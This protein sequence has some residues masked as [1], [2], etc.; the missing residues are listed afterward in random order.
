MSQP[1]SPG[2]PGRHGLRRIGSLLGLCLAA[3]CGAG[4]AQQTARIPACDP[5]NGGITLPAGFCAAVFADEIGVARH[6]VVGPDGIVYV[7]LE[8][9]RR[10]SA[11]TSRRREEGGIVI[12]RDTTGDGRADVVRRIA[13]DGGTGIALRADLLYF[14]T[15]TTVQRVRLSADRMR[16]AGPPDTLV[17]GI[18]P[19]GH[20]SRSLAFDDR[21]G[22]FVHIGSNS[23]VCTARGTRSGPDPCPELP[24]RAGI[25]RYAADQLHQQHPTAGEH[26]VTGLRN[27]VGLAWDVE[28]RK[29]YAVSHGRDG[30]ATLWPQYYTARQSAEQPSEEFVLAETG[31]DFGWPYCFHD[32]S[33]HAKVLAPEYGGDGKTVGRCAQART[34]LIG[35]PGHWGPDDLL[36]Y[37]GAMFPLKYRGGAFIA[38]HGSWNRSPEPEAGYKVVFV[39]RSSGRFGPAYETFADGFAEGHLDPGGA[40]HRPTGLAQGPDGALYITDDQRGRIWRVVYAGGRP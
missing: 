35:F 2:R 4:R 38:F 20:I 12:L 36:F 13:T 34:P 32:N 5:G 24:T 22:M 31:N 19:E 9:G 23:N 6:A 39:P 14:S 21:G 7:A 3:G 27:A 37:S 33:L 28:S 40:A 8:S 11:G 15:M 18:P 17:E 25:W 30:L 16:A 1:R 29:L 10:T 26:W